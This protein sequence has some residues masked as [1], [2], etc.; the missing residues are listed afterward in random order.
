MPR[1]Q[2]TPPPF[3]PAALERSLDRY[4]VAGLVFMLVLVA[5]F[6]AYKVREPTLRSD[7]KRSQQTT[8]VDLGT[9]LFADNCASCH[10]QGANGGSAPVLNATQ[11][12]KSTTDTQIESIVKVGVPGSD[13]DA[14]GLDYGGSFTD[15]QIAQITAY[16]RSL[17][18]NAP[19]VPDW[20]KGK[21]SP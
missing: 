4:L 17:E 5:G 2:P 7:A 6:V 19:S 20:R 3:E 14:K 9:K 16:I 1:E 8:Y 18:P 13:M 12:L 15:E 10:G 11:F 21:S